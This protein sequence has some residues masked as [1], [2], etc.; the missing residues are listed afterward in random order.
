[1]FKP[2]P[3]RR[4]GLAWLGQGHNEKR[5]DEAEG[6]GNEQGRKR[7]PKFCPRAPGPEGVGRLQMSLLKSIIRSPEYLP[8][9]RR[10]RRFE[11]FG[12]VV[13]CEKLHHY[14]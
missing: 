4:S 9:G 14:A 7:G 12:E 1:L 13:R 2:W 3:E 6:A 5:C 11:S 10:Q 8:A